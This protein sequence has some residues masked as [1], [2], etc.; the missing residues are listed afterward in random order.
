M[1]DGEVIDAKLVRGTRLAA[2]DWEL[3]APL[4]EITGTV[5]EVN[6]E[7]WRDNRIILDE[8]ILQG[9][10]TA[11][12]LIGRYVIVENEARSDAC[13]EIRDVRDD[14]TVISTGDETLIE[15]LADAKDLSAGY[16]TT[17]KRGESFTIPL[18]REL[19]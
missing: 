9:G 1:R 6:H 11:E 2:G 15:R 8:S 3:T 17:V 13:Y 18:D 4:A 5:A 14:G 16:I 7:D 19:D 10:I 12:D